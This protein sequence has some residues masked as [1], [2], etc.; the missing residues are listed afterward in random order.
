M[1][2]AASGFLFLEFPTAG[3]AVLAGAGVIVVRTGRGLAGI[4]GIFVGAG[5]VWVALFGRIK[6]TCTAEGG[7]F[8]PSID[9]YLAVSVALLLIGLALSGLAL[10]RARRH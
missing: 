7:C 8:A 9:T 4:G 5:A 6:L 10:V 2:G 1:L 3:L